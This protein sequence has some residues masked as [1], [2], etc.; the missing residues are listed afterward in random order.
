MSSITFVVGLL[1]GAMFVVLVSKNNKNTI[2]RMR[3]EILAAAHKGENEVKKVI[4]KYKT[5]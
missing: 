3:E 4:E 1:I 2:A 5:K